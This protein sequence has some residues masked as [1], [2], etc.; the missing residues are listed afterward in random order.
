MFEALMI[1]ASWIHI[2]SS[3]ECDVYLTQ[4]DF[5]HGTY[6]ISTS[7]TYCLTEDIVFD[8]MPGSSIHP[9][10]ENAWF[11]S[12]SADYPGSI[13][14]HLGPFALGFFTVLSIEISDVVVD[15]QGH[16]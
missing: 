12:D 6:R 4:T 5:N 10:V 1:L 2:S 3:H 8:P 11:P 15:L 9:N 14:Q 7:N 13:T 16:I